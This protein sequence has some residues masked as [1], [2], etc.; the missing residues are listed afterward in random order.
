MLFPLKHGQPDTGRF[1]RAR[2]HVRDRVDDTGEPCCGYMLHYR[3][4]HKS[5]LELIDPQDTL[6]NRAKGAWQSQRGWVVRER[7]HHTENLRQVRTFQEKASECVTVG[8]TIGAQVNFQAAH[9]IETS[10]T[11]LPP[12]MAVYEAWLQSL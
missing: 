2:N 12:T 9:D 1:Y 3:G 11:V 6:K 4:T 5:T 7:Q 10:G 8:D